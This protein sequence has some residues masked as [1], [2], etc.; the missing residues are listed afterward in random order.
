MRIVVD[1]YA[2]I[3]VFIG[4]RN[5]EKVKEIIE[6]SEEV[7][8]PDVVLAEIARKYLKEGVEG[9]EIIERLKVIEE[10]SEIVPIDRCI[11][12]EAAKCYAELVEKARREKLKAP[13]LFD[14]IILATARTRDA[15]LI[16]GDE[17]FKGVDKV[18]WIGF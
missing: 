5:S 10:T 7:Y 3:E 16:T 2:W 6:G 11:A 1:T 13:S 18:V 14:A 12:L 17:H 8:T 9:W 4:G 15:E